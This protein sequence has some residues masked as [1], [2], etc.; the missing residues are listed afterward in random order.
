V[1][2]QGQGQVE[3]VRTFSGQE[4]RNCFYDFVRTSFMDGPYAEE[5][6]L[7]R[8]SQDLCGISGTESSVLKEAFGHILI[9]ILN[10]TIKF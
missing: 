3:A 4:E 6:L 10:A 5:L 1:C 9:K 7:I 8:I 2:P